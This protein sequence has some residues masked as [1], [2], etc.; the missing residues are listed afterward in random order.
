MDKHQDGNG[1]RDN[2]TLIE[3]Q[4]AYSLNRLATVV[5]ELSRLTGAGPAGSIELVRAEIEARTELTSAGIEAAHQLRMWRAH[6]NWLASEL[7]A[8][9]HSFGQAAQQ[10]GQLVDTALASWEEQFEVVRPSGRIGP[11]AAP[12]RPGLLRGL[13]RRSQAQVPLPRTGDGIGDDSA[14][15]RAGLVTGLRPAPPAVRLPPVGRAHGPPSRPAGAA[16]PGPAGSAGLTGSAGT[17]GPAA[18]AGTAGPAAVADADIA[19]RVLGPL[20]LSVA[21]VRV[22]RWSSLKARAVF[23]YLLLHHGRPVRREVL[24]ELEW[25][26]HSHSSARNNLNVALCS[27]RNTLDWR[28]L[29]VPA[30]LHREGCYL[31]NPELACWTDHGEFLTEIRDAQHAR[32]AG[33]TQQVLSAC[34]SAVQLY[35]GPLFEDDLDGDWYLP[36]RRNLKDLYLQALEYLAEIY[37]ESG[38]LALAVEYGQQAINVDPCYEAAHRLLMRCFAQQHQQQLVSRQYR[39]CAAAL[40]DELDVSPTMETVQLFRMLTSAS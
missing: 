5:N 37:C 13:L 34:H 23:Q 19:A 1:N 16:R 17:A 39:L 7:D 31:L 12:G 3:R 6:Y 4:I 24:M 30:V 29:D 10:L 32:Q 2:S 15:G 8:A 36:E 11:A 21:G 9:S 25:P 35:R 27:L 18:S 14:A 28:G 38:Q 20:E 22:L 26:N 40:Q 33:H